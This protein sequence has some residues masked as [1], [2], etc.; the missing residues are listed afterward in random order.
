MKK[1]MLLVAALAMATSAGAQSTAGLGKVEKARQYEISFGA[2][3]TDDPD[4]RSER[5]G[6]L[7]VR[8]DR[9]GSG[10]IRLMVHGMQRRTIA[11]YDSYSS[12]PV[13]HTQTDT[14][15]TTERTVAVT[16]SADAVY[17]ILGDLVGVVSAGAG[18]MPYAHGTRTGASAATADYLGNYSV[19]KP[20]FIASGGLM[21]R[22]R[23]IFIE[24]GVHFTSGAG[25][26][27]RAG[28]EYLPI[29]VGLRF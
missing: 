18:V 23:W 2:A 29:S 27:L 4:T 17:R 14:L 19:S 7:G 20:G 9:N 3:L 15:R 24:Q 5:I 21:L 1:R 6:A 26:A 12:F 16:L 22:Y 25:N 28:G 10:G 11:L 8:W 13:S